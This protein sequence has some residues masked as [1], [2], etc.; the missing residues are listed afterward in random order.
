[1]AD[2]AHPATAGATASESRARTRPPRPIPAVSIVVPTKNEAGNIAALLA[3][4]D[5]AL[6]LDEAELIFVDDSTDE[7]PDVVREQARVHDGRRIE[8]V[9][10]EGDER[11][12]GLAGAVV[13]GMQRA[14]GDWVCVMDADLQHPPQLVPDLLARAARGDVDLVIASRFCGDG[15]AED[16]GPLR[17]LLSRGS[18]LLAERLFANRLRDVTDPM[19]GFFLVR[20]AAVDLDALRPDGFKIL[21]EIIVRGRPLR[22]AE[23]PFAF[24]VRHSGDSKAS[25]AE[26]ARYLRQLWRLRFQDLSARFGRFGVVGATGLLVNTLLLALFTDLLGIWY[27]AGA[28]LA[29]QGSSL[30]NFALTDR[31]VFR[32][33]G[34]RRSAASRLVAFVAMNNVALLL[35]IPVLFVLVGGLGLNHLAANLATL[36]ALTIAR[37]GLADS[38]IWS[39]AA[40][41]AQF[42]YDIHGLISI[43]SEAPLPELERFRVDGALADPTIR[44]RIGKV[45]ARGV[46]ASEL[47]ETRTAVHYVERLG[48][49]GFGAEL[50]LG[51]RVDI[52]ATP[53][54]RH[55]PHVLY[56][57]VVEPVLRWAFVERGYALVHAACMARDEDGLLI[58]ARTDTGKTTTALKTLDSLPYGF[59]S[60]DLTLLAPDGRVLT[61]PKPLTISR[62]TLSAVRSPLLTRKERL[63]LV[64]QS[65]LHSKSGRLF[66]LIIAKTRMPAATINALVQ[67]LVPPPKYHIERLIPGVEVQ[68]EAQIKAMAIIQRE[69]DE[70]AEALR[71]EDALEILLSNC[72]DAYGF[73]PYPTIQQWLHSRNGKDLKAIERAI[74]VQALTGTPA[75]LLR[76]HD[77]N[78]YRML[79]AVVAGVVGEVAR[80]A[81]GADGQELV[82]STPAGP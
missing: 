53:L 37:F 49:L 62:H 8:L 43:A 32:G 14:C 71:G 56:T 1:M 50:E 26:G 17:R 77:R 63:G 2:L 6:P 81:V 25:P 40:E 3:A 68:P 38:W 72:E 36:L 15:S 79:P 70:G 34:Y 76:S 41:R 22:T 28:V 74:I 52:L 80:G 16:F 29:T 61:Y 5:E 13:A 11:A 35:R 78:W 27:V 33:G 20:R 7:T 66:G 73:P 67:M 23:V 55:S 59:L 65:R 51:E 64:V 48:N 54:L 39:R 21:L 18:T 58:T 46:G 69:G 4:L 30:W 45:R 31:W 12:G 60:D 75:Q 42:A 47:D 9:H 24:G 10:R 44:V 57:N 82:E 19:S